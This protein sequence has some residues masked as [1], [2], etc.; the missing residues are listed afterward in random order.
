MLTLFDMRHPEA[1]KPPSVHGRRLG[2]FLLADPEFGAYDCEYYKL[3]NVND[4]YEKLSVAHDRA[5]GCPMR[6]KYKNKRF[7]Y[8]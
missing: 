1:N 5:R 4:V 2:T 3:R 8:N 7:T 6:G